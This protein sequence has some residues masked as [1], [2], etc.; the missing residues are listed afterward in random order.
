MPEARYSWRP[1][2]ALLV[3]KGL[4]TESQLDAALAEQR[5]SGRLVG[6]ILVE[7]GAVSALSLARALS[8]QHGVELRTGFGDDPEAGPAQAPA[9]WRPLGK[10]LVEEGYLTKVELRQALAKQL[11]SRGR[12]LLGEILVAEGFLSGIELA[13]AL[14]KQSGVHLDPN[15]DPAVETVL[16]TAASEQFVY[17]VY[18]VSY[19]PQYKAH[20]VL[21]ESASFLEAVDYAAEYLEDVAPNGLEIGRTDSGARETVWT[22]SA[23]RAAATAASKRD[24][25][26]MFG[27]DPTLWGGTAS[28]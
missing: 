25:A 4:L 1:L 20:E 8:E 16:R 5:R 19:E 13:R 3:D 2:G 15:E 22:Y 11:E 9:V 14:S 10:L 26:N 27:F 12:R 7:S 23:S 21:Y 24:L 17:Q 18:E 28:A 6:Q